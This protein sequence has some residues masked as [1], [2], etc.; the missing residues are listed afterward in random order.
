MTGALLPRDGS[1]TAGTGPEVLSIRPQDKTARWK[2][3][4]RIGGLI[5]IPRPATPFAGCC[6]TTQN[7]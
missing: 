7:T 1:T 2:N 3:H 5:G 6:R 4:G